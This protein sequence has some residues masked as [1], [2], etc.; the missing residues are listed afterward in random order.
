MKRLFAKKL[1]LPFVCLVCISLMF[2]RQN[3]YQWKPVLG[4]D[5]LVRMLHSLQQEQTRN[6]ILLIQTDNGTLGTISER[7][8]DSH[9]SKKLEQRNATRKWFDNRPNI[10]SSKLA[11]E[12]HPLFPGYIIENPD[13][14]KKENVDVLVYLHSAVDH[15]EVRRSIRES[16]ASHRTFVGIN[17]KL[18]FILGKPA[19]QMTQYQIESEFAAYSDIIQGNFSDTF[20]N[21]TYKAVTL[22]VWVNAHCPNARYIVKADDDMFV[23]I[24]RVISEIVPQ[25]A[26][27][28]SA[29]A[30]DV[31][32]DMPI[33]RDPRIKWY[34]NETL[35]PGRVTWPTFCSGYFLVFTGNSVLQLFEASFGI[36]QLIP[37]DDAYLFG[38]L[39]EKNASLEFVN[40]HDLISVNER[41]DPDREIIVNGKFE[42]IAFQVKSPDYHSKLWALRSSKLSTWEQIHSNFYEI[43]QDSEKNSLYIV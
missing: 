36:Q 35:L 2:V 13:V 8:S 6:R 4:E 26:Q 38:L 17:L 3:V 30:C 27:K 15:R 5:G 40:I 9:K 42:F 16:W 32:T 21:L 19:D 31:K 7:H 34:V 37:I 41:P 1:I 11:V 10:T 43:F 12:K 39:T 33:P 25:L 22:L 24:Y 29:V 23:D 28:K 14:C 18:V 20:K